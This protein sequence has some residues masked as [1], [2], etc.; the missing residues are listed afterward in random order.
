MCSITPN[1]ATLNVACSKRPFVQKQTQFILLIPAYGI[2][3]EATVCVCIFDS[4]F[5]ELA[6]PNSMIRTLP[7][8]PWF[9]YRAALSLNRGFNRIE[10]L[11][12]SSAAS[13]NNWWPL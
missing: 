10:A 9:Y 12:V 7:L 6:H 3:A 11:S 4:G 2:D 1:G 8:K 13:T 5:D